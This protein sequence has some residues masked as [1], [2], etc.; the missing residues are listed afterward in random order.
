MSRA[1]AYMLQ[2]DHEESDRLNKQSKFLHALFDHC[3]LHPSIP[4]KGLHAIA[5]VGTGTGVWMEEVQ[6]ELNSTLR[7]QSV[8]LVGFDVSEDQFPDQKRSDLEYR[9][10]DAV[11]PFP[12][13]YH[14]TFDL[15]HVRFLSYGIKAHQLEAFVDSVSQIVRE[16]E[17]PS[18]QAVVLAN[19]E[20]QAQGD[21]SSGKKSTV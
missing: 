19:A 7:G 1:E 9:V 21:I 3:I 10:H 5:D 18:H 16:S 12:A 20:L 6:Q 17:N 15:V 4:R 13:R 8:Q 14:N 11:N 2:R